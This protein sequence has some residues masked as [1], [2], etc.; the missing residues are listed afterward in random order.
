MRAL[1]ALDEPPTAVVAASDTFALGAMEVVRRA[2]LGVPDDVALV[3]FD[4]PFFGDLLDPP[5]TA[6]ARNER[7]LGELAAALLLHALQTGALGPPTEVRLPEELVVRRS[8]SCD[9]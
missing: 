7:E 9:L 8:C 2:G 4:D 3:A 5:M 1:L 6:L